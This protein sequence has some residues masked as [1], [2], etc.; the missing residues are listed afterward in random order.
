MACLKLFS[1]RSVVEIEETHG[2]RVRIRGSL[3]NIRDANH[4]AVP[5]V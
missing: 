5:I 1:Q 2:H 3:N 4:P